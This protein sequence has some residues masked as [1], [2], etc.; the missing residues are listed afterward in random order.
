MKKTVLSRDKEH[1]KVKVT[2]LM[3]AYN[4]SKYIYEAIDSVLQQ[5]FSEFELVIINDG[6]TD[7]TAEIV[8]SFHDSRIFLVEQDNGGIASALN[9]G[10]N[11]ARAEYVARFDADD[12]CQPDRLQ[13]QYNYMTRNP[14]CIVVGSA[15]DYIDMH[16]NFIFSYQ[17]PAYTND[18]I[19]K[20]PYSVCPFIHSSV[21][22]KKSVVLEVGGYNR[23]AH[24]FE[25][26]FLWL[27]IEKFGEFHN[28]AQSLIKV[29]LNPESITIDEKWRLKGFIS[30]KYKSL[31][32]QRITE[33]EGETLLEILKHQNNR[34]IK[35]GAYH[36]LL[37]KKFLW[38][39]Y[40]PLQARQNIK[41]AIA[42]NP[43][44][45][46]NY[47]VLMLSFLPGSVVSK[48]Y[49]VSK[50]KNNESSLKHRLGTKKKIQLELND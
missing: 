38:N 14:G 6:S 46:N 34:K 4:A 18:E 23:H 11:H 5:T 49:S 1:N 12:V 36:A 42:L 50:K 37:A 30:I 31:K 40:Q 35:T 41:K 7:N 44:H 39:N 19:K 26:H 10:L 15:V 28:L 24:S 8:R 2:V 33:I 22:F 45:T 13:Q 17:L 43:F 47:F 16:D 9:N 20:L 48:I 3:P 21:L 27:Q 25:D 32:D 29:R